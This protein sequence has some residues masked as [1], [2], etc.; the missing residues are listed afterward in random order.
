MIA[1]KIFDYFGVQCLSPT[2]Y[3]IYA[4]AIHFLISEALTNTS[5]LSNIQFLPS[6]VSSFLLSHLISWLCL[7]FFQTRDPTLPPELWL[8]VGYRDVSIYQRGDS[9]PITSYSY[10]K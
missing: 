8:G 6:Y 4:R 3:N 10:E 7:S 9:R 5:K 2:M 1:K